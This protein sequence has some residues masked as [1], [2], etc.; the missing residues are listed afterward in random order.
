[1]N[2]H[3]LNTF[4]KSIAYQQF[5]SS[6][7]LYPTADAA[8]IY[9]PDDVKTFQANS[10]PGGKANHRTINC[11]ATSEGLEKSRHVLTFV[12]SNGV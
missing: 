7:F 8:E 12:G 3:F 9:E 10:L 11:F 6:L 5:S 1:M 4:H 2:F